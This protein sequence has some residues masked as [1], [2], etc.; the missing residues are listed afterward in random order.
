MPQIQCGKIS[1]CQS[2]ICGWAEDGLDNFRIGVP[3]LKYSTCYHI[4]S[5]RLAEI[6]ASRATNFILATH[7]SPPASSGTRDLP[8]VI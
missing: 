5:L 7:E 2:L 8:V 1:P 6:R 3:Y 4:C